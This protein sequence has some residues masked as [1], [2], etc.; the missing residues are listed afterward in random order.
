MEFE[1]ISMKRF[2]SAFKLACK[3]N[4]SHEGAAMWLC[5]VFK[6]S[7]S[8][9]ALIAHLC[10]KQTSS[11]KTPR[12]SKGLLRTYQGGIDPYLRANAT[13]NVFADW[14]RINGIRLFFD[15]V[16]DV[17][18]RPIRYGIAP[19]R[20]IEWLCSKLDF[21]RSSTLTAPPHHGIVLEYAQRHDVVRSSLSR[22][23][24]S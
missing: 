20:D 19:M 22:G 3:P 23:V 6:E 16:A 24:H 1:L 8:S 21:F 7:F 10:F 5:D 17:K 15:Y 4:P 2:Y 14:R 12:E 11:W 18:R 13:D 9:G